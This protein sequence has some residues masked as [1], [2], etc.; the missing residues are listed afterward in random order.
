LGNKKRTK[1]HAD[2]KTLLKKLQKVY[3]KKV[4]PEKNEGTMAHWQTCYT[5]NNVSVFVFQKWIWLSPTSNIN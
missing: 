2:F 3:S 5:S 1:I 4:T